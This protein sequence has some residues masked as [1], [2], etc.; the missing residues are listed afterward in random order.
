MKTFGWSLT[1]C[2][3]LP[4]TV[5]AARSHLLRHELIADSVK[6]A[7]ASTS[8]LYAEIGN[9]VADMIEKESGGPTSKDIANMAEGKMDVGEAVRQLQGKLPSDV[10]ALVRVTK[11]GTSYD[12]ASLQKAR[13]ILND[14]LLK[15]WQELDD[16][17]F[18][19]MGFRQRNRGT[20]LQVVADLARLGSQVA[21]LG[22][23]KVKGTEGIAEMDHQR[24]VEEETLRKQTEEFKTRRLE[25]QQ[26][27]TERKND[28]AV[29][30]FILNLT[31]CS[32]AN[33]GVASLMQSSR[34]PHVMICGSK[35]NDLE[36][37]F[38]D[39]HLQAQVERMLT[40]SAK[41]ALRAALGQT[42]RQANLVQLREEPVVNTTIVVTTTGPVTTT[43]FAP[44]AVDPLPVSE[45]PHPEGQWKKCVDGTPNCGLLHDL[46]S[47]E[48]GKFRDAFDELTAEMNENQDTY[49]TIKSNVNDQLTVT[50]NEKT[51][52][53]EAL[54]SA[55][56]E[57]NAD[58]E[59][60][61][62][63][64]AQKRQLTEEF[65][66][67]CA[68]FRAKITEILHT[69]IC[70]VRK[71]RNE[72]MTYSATTPPET[73]S[74]CDF[75]DW[76]SKT[77]EC[78]TTTGKAI[79]CDDTCNV[80]VPYEEYD[81]YQCGGLE[82][83]KRDVVVL[84]NGF[85]MSCPPYLLERKRRCGQKLCSV[86]CD[87]S[88]WSGWS[89]CSKDCESGVEARTRS[90]LV[91]PKN[92]GTICDTAQ[93]ARSCNT[94]SCDRDCTL[95]DWTEW[96]PC[97]MACNK[98][99]T[100]RTRKVLVPIRGQGKCP[101]EASV[102][103][104]EEDTCNAHDCIGD[105]VCIAKQDLIIALDSSGSLREDGFHI[106]RDFTANL[107]LKYKSEYYSQ[108]AVRIGLLVFGN[109]Q[110]E[111]QPDG[112]TTI[113]PAILVEPLTDDF[114][115][116]RA[117]TRALTWQRGFTNMA[118]ALTLADVMLTQ[119]G[120]QDAQSAILILSDGKYSFKYQT[121]ERAQ[122]LKD[123]NIQLYMAPV[124][125]FQDKDL[126]NLK[127]WASQPWET[128]YELVPGLAAVK[129]N[130]D[131]FAQKLVVKFCPDS[132][133]PGATAEREKARGFILIREQ[134]WPSPSCARSF[135]EGKDVGTAEACK[136][137]TQAKG[138]TAFSWAKEAVVDYRCWSVQ[139]TFTPEQ[140]DAWADDRTNVPCQGGMWEDQQYYDT[141]ALNPR[142]R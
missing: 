60:T 103:R 115:D 114:E 16:V 46:M 63:K 48:W 58:I 11:S 29:F 59:E 127:L 70:A 109:G 79:L 88:Q 45:D 24:K 86:D 117:K 137:L 27:M 124:T 12:E 66:K 17:M 130:M 96:A 78:I 83:L 72:L 55:T 6:G 98:G 14:M 53:M 19:C 15:G 85:G 84:A 28:L 13:V 47:L 122:E 108:D 80:D 20:Y 33:G 125:D 134:G 54:A 126:E 123:K 141:Y 120:R 92:G 1:L 34:K 18:E 40:P 26:E 105:E 97:S 75:T 4:R 77:G 131:I 104:W 36:L 132:I 52:H 69:K 119:K 39:A 31:S 102:E 37:H 51:K 68:E 118:Q 90:I 140:F 133:S 49:D 95:Q 138:L 8:G 71:I 38:Q 25:N 30:D 21:R 121:A 82:T 41:L 111:T 9:M 128:N 57:Y 110:L 81:P 32:S 116:L 74:D 135:Y 99:F 3:V 56:S 129:E 23:L 67:K 65:D 5:G 89:K 107:T 91:K 35:N 94:G 43:A 62:E 64:E 113:S 61:S 50:N 76:H 112:S 101:T 142:I 100:I 139:L 2:V 93:E 136:D 22:E 7:D 42:V 10:A 87:I 106:L 44:I 73:I